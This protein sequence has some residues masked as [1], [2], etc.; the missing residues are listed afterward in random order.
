MDILN[1]IKTK[2]DEDAEIEFTQEK[3]SEQIGERRQGYLS[4]VANFKAVPSLMMSLVFLILPDGKIRPQ[5]LV[6]REQLEK[7][8]TRKQI[9]LAKKKI[10]IYKG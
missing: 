10:D 4:K 6:T 1:Y 5:D 7:Y 9:K 2:N 3:F 8:L